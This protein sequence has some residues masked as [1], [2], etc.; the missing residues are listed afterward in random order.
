MRSR[1]NS[2]SCN[3]PIPVRLTDKSLVW[4]TPSNNRSAN[5]VP[6]ESQATKGLPPP[7]GRAT[8]AV[9]N[10]SFPAFKNKNRPPEGLFALLAFWKEKLD[11]GVCG[12]TAWV[13][14]TQAAPKAP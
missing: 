4:T 3:K 9:A 13:P 11:C 10:I 6:E 2:H 5:G 8:P 12:A 1:P 7:D 14:G